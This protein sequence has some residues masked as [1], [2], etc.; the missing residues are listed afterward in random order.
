MTRITLAGEGAVCAGDERE[1]TG[2]PSEICEGFDG[3]G[4]LHSLHLVERFAGIDG[5]SPD[6]NNED[7]VAF[8]YGEGGGDFGCRALNGLISKAWDRVLCDASSDLRLGV[9]EGL[10]GLESNAEFFGAR[11][12]R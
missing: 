3:E 9:F 1:N 10:H 6:V 5:E 4:L 2:N 11:R 8:L 7:Q 12:Q